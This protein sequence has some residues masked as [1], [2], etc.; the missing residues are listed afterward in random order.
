MSLTGRI[1]V[2]NQVETALKEEILAL[3]YVIFQLLLGWT[4]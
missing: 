4:E 3:F 1:I 2:N